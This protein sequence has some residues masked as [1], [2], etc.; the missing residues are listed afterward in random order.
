MYGY[1]SDALGLRITCDG[2]DWLTLVGLGQEDQVQQIVE[3]L[4]LQATYAQAGAAAAPSAKI[5]GYAV[6][7][8][9]YCTDCASVV[10]SM[11]RETG[12]PITDADLRIWPFGVACTECRTL[13]IAPDDAAF[14][15]L[16][17][18]LG[19]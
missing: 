10:D 15:E 16:L 2:Q 14:C 11:I 9:Q 17:A 19:H 5:K 4:N 6:E 13:I 1:E 18:Q 8:F 7:G 3:A 12:D